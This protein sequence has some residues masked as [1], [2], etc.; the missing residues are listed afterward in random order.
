MPSVAVKA[1]VLTHLIALQ[2]GPS[3][4]VISPLL[5]EFLLVEA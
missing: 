2:L 4:D 1:I 3:Y 5:P